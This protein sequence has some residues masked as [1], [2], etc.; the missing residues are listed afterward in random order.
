MNLVKNLL[1]GFQ[2][3]LSYFWSC[4]VTWLQQIIFMQLCLYFLYS[5]IHSY[6]L[7]FT[8]IKCFQKWRRTN[9]DDSGNSIGKQRNDNPQK[10]IEESTTISIVRSSCLLF[11]LLLF[12]RFSLFNCHRHIQLL[13]VD[14]LNDWIVPSELSESIWEMGEG[15][16]SRITVASLFG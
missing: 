6:Y 3:T 15:A 11:Q 5:I 1:F 9:W 2:Y 4:C 12:P 13:R 14:E 10:R 7:D 16:V 8:K